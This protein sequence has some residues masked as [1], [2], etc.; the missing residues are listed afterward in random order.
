[1]NRFEEHAVHFR[2]LSCF[3]YIH[4]FVWNVLFD[5]FKRAGVSMKKE[6]SVKFLTDPLEGRCTLMPTDVFVYGWIVGKYA[7]EYLPGVSP[8]V[9]LTTENLP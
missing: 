8:I 4:D 2:G 9:G 6:A 5:V 7:C 1:M 3:K